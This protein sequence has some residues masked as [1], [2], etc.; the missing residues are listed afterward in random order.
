M[1]TIG[2]ILIAGIVMVGIVAFAFQLFSKPGGATVTSDVGGT[3]S[4][5][6]GDLFK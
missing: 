5:I 4:K 2:S 3:V 1:D 6:T